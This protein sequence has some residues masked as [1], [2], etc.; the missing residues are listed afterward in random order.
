MT[1]FNVIYSLV[2]HVVAVSINRL[3]G[4]VDNFGLIEKIELSRL[5]PI[6]GGKNGKSKRTT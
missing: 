5:K 6:L 2:E 3:I 1:P 4:R